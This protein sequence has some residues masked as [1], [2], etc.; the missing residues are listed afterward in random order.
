MTVLAGWRE[1]TG[2]TV[3]VPIIKDAPS[4]GGKLELACWFLAGQTNDK[5]GPGGGTIA[6]IYHRVTGPQGLTLDN[7]RDL[8]KASKKLGYLSPSKG[9][10]D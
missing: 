9:E 5:L 1:P 8:V 4:Y 2:T 3:Y 10:E 7:T 6:E